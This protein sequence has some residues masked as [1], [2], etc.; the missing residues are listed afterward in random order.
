MDTEAPA[1]VGD[2]LVT[3]REIHRQ[4]WHLAWPSV[5][6]ML[7]QSFNSLMDTFFVGHLPEG[8]QALAATGVGGGVVFLLVS[9]A[10]G[11]T[12]GTTALVA[13]FTGAQDPAQAARATGQSLSLAALLALLCGVPAYCW[14]EQ[15][16]SLL[17]DPG[18]N[19]QASR[20]CV[21]FLGAALL[22]TLP[23]FVWN[24]LQAAFRG[25]GDA[26][27]PMRVTGAAISVHV[28]GDWLL[29]YGH[30]GLPR[31]GV[32][33]AGVALALSWCVG[34]FLFGVAAWRHV[35]L[36][37][38]FRWRHWRPDV[39]WYG[40]ILRI[41]VPAS[42]QALVRTV[43]MMLFTGMLARTVEGAAAVA[44]LQI[45]IR[46]EGIAFM[47]GFGYGIAAS[48]LVGQALGARDAD[49]AER[50]AQAAMWQA[51][52]VMC[53]MATLFFAGAW[54]IARAF[55][56]DPQVIGLGVAYLRINALCE[57]FLAP[58]MVLTS[59]LQGAG[60]T[61]KP[62]LITVVTMVFLRL[63][64][65]SLLMFTWNLQAVGAWWAMTVT[66]VAGG[67][68]TLGLFRTGQW[69]RVRV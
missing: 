21:A 37:E 24:V 13:R 61:V 30:W 49:R 40:R 4:V 63:P 1:G 53:L 2:A 38:A 47:P 11:V 6:A 48:A 7:L 3:D 10:M 27:T 23:L 26:R 62:T 17:L 32:V 28:I 67:L 42:V 9:L 44:A 22:A 51:L 15:I 18:R 56:A 29:I 66:T 16:V 5:T 54:P 60:E 57:P 59:A 46:A 69:K 55:S 58:G 64:L 52:C 31:M 50:A 35:V 65:A 34:M 33:G 41:G 36:R 43:S 20:L 68:M 45:G 14:R 12:V 25:V 39:A 19:P 8:A